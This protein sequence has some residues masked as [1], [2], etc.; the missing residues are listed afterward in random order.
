MSSQ[1][2]SSVAMELIYKYAYINCC[3]PEI[4]NFDKNKEHTMKN[5]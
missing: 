4:V 3:K 2:S 5:V 1:I